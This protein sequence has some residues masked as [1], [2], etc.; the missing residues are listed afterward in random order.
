[1]GLILFCLVEINC[2]V[3]LR[4][5]GSIIHMSNSAMTSSPKTL[6]V[7]SLTGFVLFILFVCSCISVQQHQK[8]V[9]VGWELDFLQ[10]I[11]YGYVIPGYLSAIE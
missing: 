4:D 6:T 5:Q 7:V 2:V 3:W 9:E 11:L 10:H 8:I 1:M